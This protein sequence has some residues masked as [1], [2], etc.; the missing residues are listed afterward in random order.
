MKKL[1]VLAL[2]LG[3]MTS[4]NGQYYYNES[5]TNGNP[6]GLNNDDEFPVGGGLS[7]TWATILG[8]SQPA[9]IW[10]TNQTI[11][12]PFQFNGA[13]V[14][15]FK[16]SSSGVL[17]FDINAIAIPAYGAAALPS[18]AVPNN[19][20]CVLGLAAPGTNDI[21]VSKTFGTAPNRQ[22]WVMFSSYDVPA[23]NCWTYWSIVLEET[24]NKI[25]VVDQ[26]NSGGAGCS[27]ANFSV[28]IQV[29]SSIAISVVGSP[30]VK[31][32]SGADP[33]PADNIYY[34]FIP[35]SRPDRDMG[36]VEVLLDNFLVRSQGPFTVRGE[37]ANFGAATVN[38]MT[39]NYQIGN[40]TPVAHTLTGLN[41][42]TGAKYTFVHPTLWNAANGV[43]EVKIFVSDING[44]AD[45][46]PS[47][48]QASKIVTVVENIVPRMPLYE[49]FT[50]STCGPCRPGNV[51]MNNL[52]TQSP[53][54]G[55]RIHYQMS[56]PGTGDPYFTAEG[57]TRRTYYQ[58]NAVPN[59]QI[60]GGAASGGWTGNASSLTAPIMVQ[61][62]GRP[63]FIEVQ[64]GF[65]VTGQ[66]VSVTTRIAP[67]VN[68]NRPLKFHVAIFESPTFQNVKSNGET[69]FHY[70]MKKML[71]NGNGRVIPS[72]TAGVDVMFNDTYTFNGNFRLPNN[73]NDPINHAT[74]HS[75]ENFN[76]IGV[77]VWVQDDADKHVFQSARSV[78]G[79][80]VSTQEYELPVYLNFFPNPAQDE[81]N[82]L[83][84]S[85]Q[86]G[87]VNYQITDAMGQVVLEGVFNTQAM[88]EHIE[89]LNTSNLANGL[90]IMRISNATFNDAYKFNVAR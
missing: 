14:S 8:G 47:N 11:P 71:P 56:W 79:A 17:T 34:E 37:V 35:G 13:V 58:V 89:R 84:N 73:A 81:L 74:E 61:M 77:V 26:R 85:I 21:I 4:V 5:L 65:Q 66:T 7:T 9:A 24:T 78:K 23:A 41:I 83:V 45:Q 27:A 70:V 15:Q 54:A 12:F 82:V 63:A 2:A 31:V 6:G 52:F 60:D 33:T 68:I 36:G 30:Q 40:N 46:N 10:S 55:S 42:A 39:V 64:S 38:S 67:G 20:V 75:I 53:N 19:S 87:A 44:G 48:D 57:Q 50:S 16:V 3:M 43:F 62:Q 49:V 28:G 29:N 69:E 32:R 18:T 86:G 76:N 51:N 88:S 22:H 25:Y 90:Y 72:L 1:Y 80:N 59:L